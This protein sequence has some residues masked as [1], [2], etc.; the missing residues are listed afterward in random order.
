MA[1]NQVSVYLKEVNV[2]PTL[3][4]FLFFRYEVNYHLWN[5]NSQHTHVVVST[6]SLT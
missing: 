5:I 6:V 3:L 1:H 4:Y 2:T